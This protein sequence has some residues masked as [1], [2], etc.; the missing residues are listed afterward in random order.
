MK[1]QKVRIT[2]A[3]FDYVVLEKS[4]K[5]ISDTVKRTGAK[6]CG[7]VPLPTMKEIFTVNRSPHIDKKSREQFEVR[8][9]KRVLDIIDPLPQTLDALGKIELA[10]G[11]EVT[12]KVVE[13]K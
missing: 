7:P 3:S 2:L 11:V 4:T 9:H 10:A 13:A 1:N 8:T 5:V 6:V 12:I